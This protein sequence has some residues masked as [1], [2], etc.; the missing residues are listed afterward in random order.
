MQHEIIYT[1]IRTASS[2]CARSLYLSLWLC[3]IGRS[4]SAAE[5]LAG[6]TVI[7]TG[8]ATSFTTSAT[9]SASPPGGRTF[10]PSGTPLNM[11]DNAL[12]LLRSSSSWVISCFCS[13][14][15]FTASWYST[16]RFL[17]LSTDRNKYFL[18]YWTYG[19]TYQKVHSIWARNKISLQEA[20]LYSFFAFDSM[21]KTDN[22][23]LLQWVQPDI[24]IDMCP[25]EVCRISKNT[26]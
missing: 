8:A 22:T 13:C 23:S 19:T 14:A 12:T 3:M 6:S 16:C 18:T 1:S 5:L 4:E 25:T 9:I 7:A 17:Y 21:Y 15:V 24:M 11:D 2:S 10:C 26:E 20:N